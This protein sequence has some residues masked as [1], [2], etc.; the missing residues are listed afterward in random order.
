M[1][2]PARDRL[3]RHRRHA[4]AAP[5]L[6]G[7]GGDQ[8]RQLA[9]RAITPRNGLADWEV[10]LGLAKAMARLLEA[11]RQVKAAGGIGPLAA[12]EE[13]FAICRQ[14]GRLR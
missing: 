8:L 14:A 1:R 5:G 13:L 10:T 11:E 6:L 3:R 12:D 9:H 7:T 2:D 4:L